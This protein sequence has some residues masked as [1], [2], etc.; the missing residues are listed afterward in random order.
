MELTQEKLEQ[1][2]YV[3]QNQDNIIL[4]YVKKV[5]EL[6]DVVIAISPITELFIW[7]KDPEFE[8][9]LMD[10]IKI[11]VNTDDLEQIEKLAEIID[12]IEF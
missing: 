10:G 12:F 4:N 8:D 1:R 9:P 7:V 11:H 5:T 3:L 2:G 6:N